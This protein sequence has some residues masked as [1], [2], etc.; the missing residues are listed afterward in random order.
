MALP[1]V[2]YVFVNSTTA[3]ANAVNQNFADLVA[4]LTDGTK[5]LS[6][7]ALIAAGDLTANGN[8]TL[9]NATSDVISVV[10]GLVVNEAGSDV[11][12][13]IEGDTDSN[14]FFVDAGTD[15]IGVGTNA[16]GVKLH[17]KSTSSGGTITRT[18]CTDAAGFTSYTAYG[19]ANTTTLGQLNSGNTGYGAG[20]QGWGF[21]GAQTNTGFLFL[22]NNAVTGLINTADNWS[23]GA[24][25][26]EANTKMSIYQSGA[27]SGIQIAHYASTSSATL[28]YLNAGLASGA[29]STGNFIYCADGGG[30]QFKVTGQGIIYAQNTTIQAISDISTKENIVDLDKGLETILSLKPRRFDFIEG[31][32]ANRKN[33]MGFIAQEAEQVVPE[34]VSEMKFREDSDEVK[35]TIGLTDLIPVLV[36]AIQDLKKEVDLLKSK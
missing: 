11:D 28:L 19:N 3:D 14:L 33:V 5:S 35:K 8:V 27:N 4:A 7:D 16:P 20:F 24:G 36:K 1:S 30:A 29:L 34:I 18:E 31:W 13:R 25:S 12:T 26:G 21:V 6:I 32:G 15:R 10:G 22:R 9:G 17:V 23:F 2:T